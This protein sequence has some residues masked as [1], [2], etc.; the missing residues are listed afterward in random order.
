MTAFTILTRENEARRDAGRETTKPPVLCIHGG[1]TNETGLAAPAPLRETS[2]LDEGPLPPVILRL[3][4]LQ[5][6]DVSHRGRRFAT[7]SQLYWAAIILG[8]LLAMW[9]ILSGGKPT[10]QATDDPPAWTRANPAPTASAAPS[11]SAETGRPTSQPPRWRAGQGSAGAQRS[12]FNP[13]DAPNSQAGQPEP[14]PAG[15]SELPGDTSETVM[16]NPSTP[17][18]SVTPPDAP[19]DT[20]TARAAEPRWDGGAQRAKP[21]EAAPL[22]IT[23]VP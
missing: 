19:A 5:A 11:W 1:R 4:D 8:A 7:E 12:E 22:G 23:P 20:F 15:V 6:A 18:E 3:P 2:V 13:L 16:S 9:L 21:G 14:P 10:P 17:G